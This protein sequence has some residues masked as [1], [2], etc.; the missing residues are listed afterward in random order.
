MW[1]AHTTKPTTPIAD[2]RVDHAQIAEDRLL[3]EGRD[4]VAD[5]A[6]ARQDHDVDFR[7]A[8][9]PEQML[10][11]HRIAAAGRVEE[12]GAEIAVADQ[13]GDRA[14]Q[15]RHRQHQQER[16]H[17][18]RPDEQRHLV[19][20]HAGRAHVE[21]RG[22]EVHRAQQRTGAGE[23]QREQRAIHAHA[24][25]IGRVRQRRIQRPAGAGLAH[26]TGR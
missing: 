26:A 11:Q 3:A 17:Q 25:F 12:R 5:D 4:H 19:Q 13:H 2:H 15:H 21:D 8:E 18:Y 6:E 20:R 16:R 24:R 14:R 9:E 7:M 10:E 23:M 22:D 1:C